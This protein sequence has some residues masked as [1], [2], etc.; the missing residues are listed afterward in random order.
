MKFSVI[1]N[2]TAGKLK[3]RY[4]TEQLK[5]KFDEKKVPYEIFF[6][7]GVGHA[8]ILAEKISRRQNKI[9]I[10]GGDGTINEVVNGIMRS[11]SDAILGIVPAGSG[12]DLVKGLGIGEKIRNSISTILGERTRTIDV[13][14]CN[15]RFFINIMGVGFDAS[16]GARMHELRMRSKKKRGGS[17]Y[18]KALFHTIFHFRSIGLEID[19]DDGKF[20]DRYFLVSIANGT[21]F[22]GEFVIAPM[23]DLSDGHLTAVCIRDFSKLRFFWHLPK[24]KKGM[25][26]DL[27]EVEYIPC[28]RLTINS[29]KAI[30]AQL[31]G[32]YY[33]NDRFEIEVVPSRIEMLVP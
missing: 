23:A 13:G 29:D 2:P 14:K 22:G 7:E 27:P 3:G 10:V 8:S 32:E 30:P 4:Y 19:I 24:V 28:K 33:C 17:F 11:G 6:T 9:V 25:I 5:I 31:D 1:A 12:N 20:I 21:T 26:L 18:N 15:D 16:V